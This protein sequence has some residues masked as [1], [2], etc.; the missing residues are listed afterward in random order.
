[1]LSLCVS[2]SQLY[3]E[4]LAIKE[5]VKEDHQTENERTDKCKVWMS[6]YATGGLNTSAVLLLPL[7]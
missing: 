4:M 2:H 5:V 7:T 1:M 6:R 3:G